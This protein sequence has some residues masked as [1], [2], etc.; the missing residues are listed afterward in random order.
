MWRRGR[1]NVNC[2][3]RNNTCHRTV[4]WV[5]WSWNS[6]E[7]QSGTD[8]ANAWNHKCVCR[9]LNEVEQTLDQG[10]LNLGFVNLLGV[11]EVV[12]WGPRSNQE[13][14]LVLSANSDHYSA[15]A[16]CSLTCLC[17][18]STC[19]FLFDFGDGNWRLAED[20]ILLHAWMFKVL[21]PRSDQI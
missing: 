19:L 2:I 18:R 15:Y 10:V 1:S 13:N 8:Q 7:F 16:Y 5:G 12:L 14:P 3:A 21:K 20:W 6:Y 11:H 17:C 9:S 4:R